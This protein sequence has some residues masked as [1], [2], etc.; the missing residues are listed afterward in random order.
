MRFSAPSAGL[1]LALLCQAAPVEYLHVKVPMRDGVRLCANVFLP[2]ANGRFP[3]LLARTPYRKS[4]TL[5]AG[6]KAF[7]DQGYA[8]VTQD[9]R[10]RY[11]SE[12]VFQQFTQEENDGEDTLTW[13]AHQV[14]SNGRVGM[15]GG[16]YLGIAQWRAALSGHPALLAIAPAV[17]GG[18][19]YLDRY[20]SRGGAFRLAHRLSWI[21]ENL[22]PP[23]SPRPDYQRLFRTIPLRAADQAAVRHRLDFLQQV[24]DH[25]L[26]D[27]YWQSLSTVERIE[28]VRVPALIFAGWYDSYAE[29]DLAMFAALRA[30]GRPARIVVGCW[31]HNLSP[32]MQDGNPPPHAPLAT[33][34][35]EIEWFNAWLKKSEPPPR[36]GVYYYVMGA[37]EWRESAEWPPPTLATPL[38]LVSR[39]H[40]NTG[41]GNGSLGRSPPRSSAPDRFTYDPRNPVPTIGGALCCNQRVFSWGPLDQRPAEHRTDVLV[42]T[43]APLKQA[44]EVIGRVQVVLHVATTALDT[45]FTAKLI[46]VFPDGRAR[47]LCDGILRLRYRE[48]LSREA[49]YKP[50]EVVRITVPLGVTGNRF[51]AGHHIRVDVSSS[52]FPR[53]DRNPNT[54]TPVAAEKRTLQAVQTVYHDRRHPSYVLLPLFVAG[55]RKPP[56]P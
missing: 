32:S 55:S 37:D 50:G 51:L 7:V 5:N 39:G 6:L 4:E 30:L 12:G 10:G 11:D 9:V 13:I 43:S 48:G 3:A 20:Y 17:C 54:G 31:G 42:F 26:Y 16:S 40:A 53:F 46:D 19:E 14:W 22:K 2:D 34:R 29:S 33:R 35:L 41:A 1:V 56:L 44:L 24:F 8:V 45:D 52:N 25:P 27:G 23:N 38:Y 18:D 49:P 15:F 28:Q 36:S 47:L 21:A